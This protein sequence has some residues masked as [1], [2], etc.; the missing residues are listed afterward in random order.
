MSGHSKWSTIK[1]Q[2]GAADLK[3]G[4]LFSRLVRAITVA[5]REGSDPETNPKLRLVIEKAKHANMP[6]DRIKRA[7]DRAAGKGSETLE[8]ISYE[9]YGPAGVAI[10]VE[11]ITDNR[12]RTLAE[13]KYLFDKR[14]GK[15]G[16][17]G[18]VEHLFSQQGLVSVNLGN[19]SADELM[20]KAIDLGAIDVGQAG[21]QIVVTTQA[22][23][24]KR[25]KE[26]LTQAGYEVV[27][28]KLS[29]EPKAPVVVKDKKIARKI[30]TL[31]DELEQLEDVQEIY[32][33]FD[34]DNQVLEEINQSS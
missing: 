34:I 28:A 3:R 9:G 15:L 29:M 8:R 18:T 33:N 6:K 2:K 21:K 12:Q 32:A 27:E 13:I 17:Q 25:I 4:K 1:R 7:I 26:A 31:I 19:K 10:L 20:L 14:S 5:A 11:V 30:L 24:L 16:K 22:N 23:E